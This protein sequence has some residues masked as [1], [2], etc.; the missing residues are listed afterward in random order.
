MVVRPSPESAHAV[1]TVTEIGRKGEVSPSRA[2]I[3]GDVICGV[4][5]WTIANTYMKA[6]FAK[7][8]L[9]ILRLCVDVLLLGA[10]RNPQSASAIR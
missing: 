2:G 3:V 8:C 1:S 5:L 10:L 9:L 7:V 4:R 6:D